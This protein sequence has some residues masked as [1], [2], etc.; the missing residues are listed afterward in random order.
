MG[1]GPPPADPGVAPR[2]RL[3]PRGEPPDMSGMVKGCADD[4][5]PGDRTHSPDEYL[6]WLA[7]VAPDAVVVSDEQGLIVLANS[8]AER[9]FGYPAE[10]M[11]GQPI[12]MLVPED[13]RGRHRH[14]RDAHDSAVGSR[15]MGVGL[16]LRARR[17]ELPV[18]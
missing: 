11:L 4:Q 10:E 1:P 5:N 16:A 2:S 7:T 3:K 6:V 17:R 12:E 15:E 8:R 13:A 14:L 18:P 9:L